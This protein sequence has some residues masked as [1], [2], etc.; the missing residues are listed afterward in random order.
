VGGGLTLPIDA[1][2]IV[3]EQSASNPKPDESLQT[4]LEILDE[5]GKKGNLKATNE[6]S[7]LIR[8]ELLKF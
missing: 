8:L 4:N 5:C 1:L 3:E 2:R 6:S 7:N